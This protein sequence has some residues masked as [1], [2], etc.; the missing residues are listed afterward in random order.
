MGYVVTNFIAEKDIIH[1]FN[2]PKEPIRH[3]PLVYKPVY[4]QYLLNADCVVMFDRPYL[5]S[6]IEKPFEIFKHV[7]DYGTGLYLWHSSGKFNAFTERAKHLGIPIVSIGLD[8]ATGF[9]SIDTSLKENGYV[10][11]PFDNT[12]LCINDK[13]PKVL[14]KIGITKQHNIVVVFNKQIP[15]LLEH[16]LQ[17]LGKVW[18]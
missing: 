15:E 10:H 1:D 12:Y 6:N 3:D 18:D 14:K 11:C 5:K 7:T 4:H 17:I 13:L 2:C 8:R 16:L 9:K